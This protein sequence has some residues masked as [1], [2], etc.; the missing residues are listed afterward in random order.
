VTDQ[1][2]VASEADASEILKIYSP[3]VRDTIISFELEPPSIEE[4]SKRI[5]NTLLTLPW[6]VVEGDGHV[7]AYAYASQH[8]NRLAYQWSVD[9][10]VYVEPDAKRHGHAR[11]LY[12]TLLEIL[13]AQGYFNVYAGIAQPNPASVGLHETMGFKLIAKYPKVGF[14][15][16]EWRDVGW[17]G[18]QL[19]E[20]EAN[21]KPP[22]KFA[23]LEKND[24]KR[25][26]EKG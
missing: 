6:L 24:L 26:L 4:I 5:A 2:R 9:V 14:K 3:I 8:R 12:E 19:R 21:P 1:V 7:V 13:R 22:I 16:G 23:D 25:I 18:L 15:L 20:F 11:R 17:W 10:S